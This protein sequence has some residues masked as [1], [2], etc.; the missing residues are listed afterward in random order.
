MDESAFRAGLSAKVD[1]SVNMDR[2]F[3]SD[4]LDFMLFFSSMVSFIK[5]AGQ[6]NYSAGCTFQDSFAHMLQ[7][8]PYAV[9]TMNWGYWGSV[10]VA[11]DEAHRKNMA[12]FG[13]GSIEPHEGMAG[14][15]A[16]M[17]SD[18]RQVAFVKTLNRQSAVARPAAVDAAGQT[19]SDHIRQVI[20]TTLCDE[21][22]LDAAV[23]RND[24]PLPDYGV[25]SI[26]G[27][28]LVRRIGEA[29]QI[30]LEPSSLFEYHT[31]NQLTAHIAAN[32]PDQIAAQVI[33]QTSQAAIEVPESIGADGNVRVELRGLSVDID[34]P[35]VDAQEAMELLRRQEAAVVA[36]EASGEQLLEE[37]LWQEASLDDSYEKVTF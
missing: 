13:L 21:L 3:G 29:L 23:V 6:S 14:L 33:P 9:K 37:L 18:V 26:V 25:D 12:R 5:S 27:V 8:R 19:I 17:S 4:A 11:A 35:L 16:L 1:I 22:L 2:V 30:P 10:G 31:V 32:W 24:A 28:N 34:E 7:Q 20:L 36:T 15:Q